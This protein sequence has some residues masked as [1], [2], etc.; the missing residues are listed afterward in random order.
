MERET[1]VANTKPDP[2]TLATIENLPMVVKAIRDYA[3]QSDFAN[4]CLVSQQFYHIGNVMLY[5]SVTLLSKG[6]RD[7]R[8]ILALKRTLTAKSWL[9]FYVRRLHCLSQHRGR[10]SADDL[11]DSSL[12]GILSDLL[13]LLER[14]EDLE[15][16]D[17]FPQS[18]EGAERL[19]QSLRWVPSL[20]RFTCNLR[21]PQWPQPAPKLYAVNTS[22]LKGA[23]SLPSLIS[24]STTLEE[25]D[26][27]EA[28]SLPANTSISTLSLNNLFVST[29]TF[30]TILAALPQITDLNLEFVR[31]ID[32]YDSHVSRHVDCRELQTA[33]SGFTLTLRR[34][35]VV[36]DFRSVEGG[37]P[38]QG[39]GDDAPW[40][41]L[42]TLDLKAFSML[43][44]LE[45]SPELLL[46]WKVESSPELSACLPCHLESLYLR[47]DYGAWY[48]S[49]WDFERLSEKLHPY[50]D[51][52]SSLRSL[53]VEYFD[54]LEDE[55]T[56]LSSSLRT[57]CEHAGI[58]FRLRLI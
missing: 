43:T 14:L 58:C 6:N 47:Y 32:S 5:E 56:T 1:A 23:L 30:R 9:A 29:E 28:L 37:D 38:C 3:S 34:L 54:F 36:A 55:I 51:H 40:G 35:R 13:S 57:Q 52:Q 53:T 7:T 17:C 39:G 33:I 42:S 25:D 50:I 20:R 46:G 27:A 21:V 45:L 19:N 16:V 4:L 44:E 41:F 8:S 10:I 24:F 22:I 48:D 12:L 26:L 18:S 15:I 11:E 49:V 31:Y 2:P